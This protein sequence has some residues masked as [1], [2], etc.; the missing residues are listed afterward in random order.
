VQSLPILAGAWGETWR[1]QDVSVRHAGRP[2]D[3][4]VRHAGTVAALASVAATLLFLVT[5]VVVG[6]LQLPWF[7]LAA[8]GAVSAC[9]VAGGVLVFRA[10][11][12]IPAGAIDPDV[13]RRIID[14][15]VRSG[16]RLTVTAVAHA[17]AMPMADADKALSSLATA[18]HVAVDND[19]AS[20]VVV[21]VF[22]DIDAGLVPMRSAP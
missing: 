9:L 15:A 21:Y 11:K 19:P 1:P 10:R 17:L 22:P 8:P 4:L 2:Q 14:V 7:L 18:G 20:G 12:R 16:G 13:E 6:A 3:V 5:V